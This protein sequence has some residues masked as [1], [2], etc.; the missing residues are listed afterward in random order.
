MNPILILGIGGGLAVLLLIIGI[1]VTVSSERSLAEQRLGRYVEPERVED[2]KV[3]ATPVAD[4]LN[5]KVEKSSWGDSISRDL[6][7][8]DLKLKPGEYITILF[9]SAIVF[10][11][12]LFLL[13]GE[14]AGVLG[15]VVGFFIPRFY[16]GRQKSKRL[17]KFNDQLGDMLNLM[18]NGLRAGYSTMQAMEAVSKELPAP[19][20][21]E[22]R[23]LVQEITLGISM[24]KALDNL[25]RRIPS[26]DLDLCITAINVQREVGGNLA[27]I[28]DTI[29]YTI[30]ERVRIKGEIRVLTTQVMY[31]G[32]F[33]SILPILVIFALYLLNKE[34]ML[35]YL[36]NG[37]CG[38]AALGASLLLIFSGYMVMNKI[39][40]IEV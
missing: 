21:D 9:G 8:A 29:S 19:I 4:W 12:I 34:Y 13:S 26:D 17:R 38:Y 3:K 25:L 11:I 22:F 18:V 33:L 37:I 40:N 24:E 1:A 5:K 35:E 20:C 6:A 15:A 32:K 16:V 2:T 7:R 23:R 14:I 31:S 39:G 36:K 10:A 30:R 27:E 28:L